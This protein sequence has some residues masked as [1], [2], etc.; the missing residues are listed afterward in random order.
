MWLNEKHVLAFL[1]FHD[2]LA[3][4]LL[5]GLPASG[6]KTFGLEIPPERPGTPRVQRGKVI[7]MLGLSDGYIRLKNQVGVHHIIQHTTYNIRTSEGNCQKDEVWLDRNEITSYVTAE[8][9]PWE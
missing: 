4:Q 1:P 5:F 6:Q 8:K 9:P 3:N 7:A 2:G